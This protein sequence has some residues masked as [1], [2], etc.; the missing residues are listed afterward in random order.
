MTFQGERG[1]HFFRS[2]LVQT[3]FYGLF[4]AWV[5]WSEHHDYTDTQARFR[6]RE[7]AQYL[8]IPI[9]QKL[10]WDF[11]NPTQLGALKL[12]EVLDWAAEALNRVDRASFFATF[13]AQHAVQYFYEPFLEAFDPE[14][15]KQL[16]V[17]YT[18]PEI[19][20]YMVARVD[21][22][23]RSELDISDGLA[24]PRVVVLDPC[25][26]TGAYLVEVL[27]TIAATLHEKGG[28]GL[29]AHDLKQA[30]MSRI[31]GFEILPAPFVISHLQIGMLL[32]RLG[33]PL[34]DESNERAGVYLTNALTGWEPPAEPK[35]HLL[36][37]EMEEERDKAEAVKQHQPILVIL[38]N[39]PYNIFASVAVSEERELSNAYRTTKHVA[40]PQG[41]GLND[42]YVRFFRMAERR[43]T[44]G[45]QGKGIVCFISNYSWLD[46][47]SFT[48]MR[49]RFLDAFD[50]IWIDCLNG[51]KY[52]TGKLT[53]DGKPDPSVF[54]TEHNHEG[55][56]VG[57]AVTLLARRGDHESA[58]AVLLRDF[59]GRE[60]REKLL[61]TLKEANRE[62]GHLTPE[63][64]VGLPFVASASETGYLGWPRLSEIL[65]ASFPGLLTS[66]DDFVIDIDKERLL[67][68]LRRYFDPAI[69]DQLI[70]QEMPSAI[71]DASRFDGPKTRRY[72][73]R[74]G[75]IEGNIVRFAYRPFD[76]RWLYW[77]PE[78][79]LL[80]EKRSEYFPLVCPDNLWI[81]ARQRQTKSTF[82]RGYVTSVLADSFGAGCSSF[83]PLYLR[84]E[85]LAP[86]LLHQDSEGL[87][88]NQTPVA[89]RYLES[90]NG[91]QI[92]LFC[93]I[94]GT[95]HA[96][97]YRCE[98]AGA[99]RQDWPRIPLPA[100]PKVFRESADLG[101]DVGHLLDVESPVDR[102]TVGDIRYELRAI[103]TIHKGDSSQVNPDAGDLAVTAGW[104]HAGQSGVTMPGHGHLV[105]RA[106]TDEEL[107]AFREGLGDLD[108]SFEQL[109]A[110]FGETC[111][112]VYL[113]DHAF[114]RCIP[115]RVWT[116]TIGGYQVIKKWLS[117]RE[118]PLLG[119]D[120][121]V[122]E[123]RYVTEM[124]RRIAAIL[125]LEPA[126]DAI[127]EQV[128]TDTYDWQGS[129][130]DSRQ[131][132]NRAEP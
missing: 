105:E 6:W 86:S 82:D 39:P 78:T 14:L 7:A 30:A 11:A 116:H 88:A 52:R 56:Q 124:A 95:M 35:Q 46:G 117:Y 21:Q 98:N 97:A 115:T 45:Q 58:D 77:E 106:Y 92:D 33:A 44:E 75:L 13:E 23:L 18:P 125:L 129:G 132:A 57:T 49:E 61:E 122:D 85:R 34:A 20:R 87:V 93:H 71:R 91:G 50:R 90:V 38:G 126:L 111:V 10:F 114:W 96:P 81:E 102:V 123:A 127:Y 118:R 1:E 62:Y 24:D 28:D 108:L 89:L 2:T 22:V 64:A 51:D 66:R 72:L 4:A 29:L 59:W 104:G 94:V 73:V 103:G 63:L 9:L 76:N 84:P 53:P 32:H 42:L 107:A 55:I 31:F 27:N 67:A 19:V 68:R 101:V 3:L 100:A 60:K 128:K 113:N 40:S 43:I 120:L 37:T 74:R 121:T 110:S 26:G 112:D 54:S 5:F 12:D 41:R 47:L 8:R 109:I 70:L 119:R 48:G 15:R 25:C 17:W 80:H 99:L 130:V 65:P 79:K 69:S 83:F 131:A 16:G 36:F